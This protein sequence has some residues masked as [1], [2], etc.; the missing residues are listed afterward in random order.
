M[1]RM[2][3]PV[4]RWVVRTMTGLGVVFHACELLCLRL[5][6]PHGQTVARL[7][8]SDQVR[9]MPK[10][11]SMRQNGSGRGLCHGPLSHPVD[12][13]DTVGNARI[14]RS[15]RLKEGR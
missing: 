4:P 3:I 8:C 7:A 10:A 2:V 15:S 12:V 14:E 11:R 9:T 6:E 5:Y 1:V 13:D